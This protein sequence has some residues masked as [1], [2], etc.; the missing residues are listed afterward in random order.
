MNLLN[1]DK[2]YEYHLYD[3]DNLVGKGFIFESKAADFYTNPRI[4]YFIE[5]ELE[6]GNSLEQAKDIVND[7]IEIARIRREKHKTSDARIYNCSFSE[8]KELIEFYKSIDGFV[9]DE[10]M[11]VLTLNIPD[12]RVETDLNS[13]FNI[14]I[15]KLDTE[16]K[17]NELLKHHGESFRPGLYIN[18]DIEELKQKNGYQCVTIRKNNEMVANLIIFINENDRGFLE[19]MFVNKDFRRQG[20]GQFLIN[21]ATD[22]MRNEGLKYIDLEVWSS[23]EKAY[24]LYKKMGYK[25]N[26]ESEVSIGMS[27]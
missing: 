4:N 19:D 24:N 22:Y 27:I 8:N 13:Q 25:F 5:F 6:P 10:A 11:H 14:E 9:A 12:N 15:N 17:M 3:S 1:T 7:L 21:Y 16:D 18:D 20:L 23:N 26:R 2:E